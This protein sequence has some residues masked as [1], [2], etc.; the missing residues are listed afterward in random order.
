[1][2]LGAGRAVALRPAGAVASRPAGA[3]VL[4][5]VGAAVSAAARPARCRVCSATH[6]RRVTTLQPEP[7]GLPLEWRRLQ[8]WSWVRASSQAQAWSSALAGLRRVLAG[9]RAQAWSR[10]WWRVRAW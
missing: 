4:R 8:A 7:P 5:S 9:L 2:V 10:A 1:M 3:A 6:L